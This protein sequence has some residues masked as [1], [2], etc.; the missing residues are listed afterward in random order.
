T[1]TLRRR[2]AARLLPVFRDRGLVRIPESALA[3]YV[4]TRTSRPP[5]PDARPQTVR[6]PSRPRPSVRRLFDLPDPLDH[7]TDLIKDHRRP[8]EEAPAAPRT[9]RGRTPGG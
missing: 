5:E 1:K 8:E 6:A 7:P 9:P 2:I 3:A 4:A